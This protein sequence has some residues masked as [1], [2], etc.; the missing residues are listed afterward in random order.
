MFL[1]TSLAPPSAAK[2]SRSCQGRVATFCG[3]ETL[4]LG[5]LFTGYIV[6][7]VCESAG[8]SA[9]A[10]FVYLCECV[11]VWWSIP[12]R[13]GEPFYTCTSRFARLTYGVSAG[14]QST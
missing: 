3:S 5:V 12:L 6:N 2:V 9:R 8:M 13:E 4:V 11:R 1:A 14:R 10:V 7:F